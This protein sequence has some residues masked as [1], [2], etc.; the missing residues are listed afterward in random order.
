MRRPRSQLTTL[1]VALPRS[2]RD[3][4]QAEAVRTGCDTP[5]EFVQ[6]LILDARARRQ[7]EHLEQRLLDGLASR[8][9]TMSRA[10]WIRVRQGVLE[11]IMART[12]AD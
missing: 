5:S 8:S 3:W 4:V 6:L 10:D 1:N 7:K 9:R 2:Q 11:S 12:K